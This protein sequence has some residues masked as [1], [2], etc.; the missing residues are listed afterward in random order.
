[1]R[2]P[3]GLP[4]ED[5]LHGYADVALF[6]CVFAVTSP[7]SGDRTS[8][9]IRRHRRSVDAKCAPILLSRRLALAYTRRM[10]VGIRDQCRWQTYSA[11]ATSRSPKRLRH[12]SMPIPRLHEGAVH[13]ILV[14]VERS[15]SMTRL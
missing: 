5:R 13:G 15:S 9:M 11:V 8:V 12:A 6:M 3:D 10:T 2:S 14:Q 1:M 7:W 4:P